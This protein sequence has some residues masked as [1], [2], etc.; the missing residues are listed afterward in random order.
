MKSKAFTLIELLVVIAIIAILAAILFPVF[1]Q[2]KDAAK[3]TAALSNAKQSGMAILMYSNDQDDMFPPTALSTAAEWQTWQGLIQPYAKNWEVTQ[4]PKLPVPSGPQFYWQRLQHWGVMPRAAAVEGPDPVY[5]WTQATLTGG[6]EV[7]FDGIF[8]AAIAPGSTW[9]AM[10]PAPS[11]TQ[12]AI[13]GI[14]TTM[15]I[16]ESNNWDMWW[17]IYG[18]GYQMGWCVNWGEGW[19]QPGNS[20]IFGPVARKRSLVPQSG[21]RFPNGQTTYVATDG[22]AKSMD[23]RGQV[24]RRVQLSDGTFVHPAMWPHSTN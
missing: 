20:D 16:A 15:M 4:H 13:D 12:T 14:S 19:T 11:L 17:G 6:Q 7:Q 8:G 10:R 24:L 18:Q 2:A 23:Y 1:S 22:S 9:Y 5:R 3:D 21:C